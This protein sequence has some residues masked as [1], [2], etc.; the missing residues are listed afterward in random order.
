MRVTNVEE[1]SC[2][3]EKAK[4]D[5]SVQQRT[6]TRCSDVLKQVV[7]RMTQHQQQMNKIDTKFEIITC[8]IKDLQEYKDMLEDRIELKLDSVK[9]QASG[10]ATTVRKTDETKSLNKMEN[11]SGELSSRFKKELELIEERSIPRTCIL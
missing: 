11:F 5:L 6:I 10:T 9:D 4:A 7:G 3:V 2:T 8:E 1:L